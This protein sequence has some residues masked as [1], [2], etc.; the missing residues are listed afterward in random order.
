[1]QNPENQHHWGEYLFAYMHARAHK[2]T[3][4]P[5]RKLLVLDLDETLIH[6]NPEAEEGD[7]LAA[8]IPVIVRPGARKFLAQMAKIFDLAVWTSSTEDYASDIVKTL[9]PSP[10]MF[11]WCRERCVRWFNPEK[12]ETEYVKDLKKLRRLGWDL[13]HVLVVDDSPEKLVRNYGNLVR[14]PPFVGGQDDILRPLAAFLIELSVKPDVRRIEKR[15]W[16]A[17]YRTRDF[18]RSIEPT[19]LSNW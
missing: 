19:F 4:F 10:P 6:G 7:F 16:L 8:G 17:T 3:T 13:A 12:C 1:M 2:T 11:L 5:G 14:V 18:R 9:F 15:G